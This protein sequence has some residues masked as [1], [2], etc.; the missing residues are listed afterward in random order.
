MEANKMAQKVIAIF[1][2]GKA[3]LGQALGALYGSKGY[4]VALLERDAAHLQAVA[5]ALTKAGIT[6][7]GIPTDLSDDASIAAAYP[8]IAKLGD[9]DT[10]VFNATVR[11]QGRPSTFTGA[12]IW[13]DLAVNVASAVTVSNLAIPY[14]KATK[15]TLLYTGSVV[16]AKPGTTDTSQSMGKA[17][18]RNYALA[19]NKDLAKDNI[20]AGVVTIWTYIRT[21][22]GAQDPSKIAQAYYDL[23]QAR[24]DPEVIYRGH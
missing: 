17:A 2:V 10:V 22:H 23:A 11:R 20:F 6:A 1:G 18:M 16:A 7:Q 4:A 15:G 3:G 5:G 14:L 19:L 9:L 13:A 12:D 8:Q 24:K 21:G